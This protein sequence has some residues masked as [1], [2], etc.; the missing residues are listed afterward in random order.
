MR[1]ALAALYR[2]VPLR[3]TAPRR[4]REDRAPYRCPCPAHAVVVAVDVV[5]RV[6]RTGKVRA[7]RVRR[8]YL[9]LH[10]VSLSR[11][12]PREGVVPLRVRRRG[13]YHRAAPIDQPHRQP[14]GSTFTG[15]LLSVVVHVVPYPVPYAQPVEAE[16]YRQVRVRVPVAVSRRLIAAGYRDGRTGHVS[17][18]AQCPDHYTVIDIVHVAV[19]AV[20]RR[21]VRVSLQHAARGEVTLRDHHQVGQVRRKAR[22]EAREGIVSAVRR[23]R[24]RNQ[25]IHAGRVASIFIRIAVKLHRHAVDAHF[26][27]IDLPAVVRV[28]PHPVP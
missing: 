26:A 7:A 11:D 22:I 12:Q 13:R 19:P 24:R 14:S 5:P 3:A 18:A 8:R 21:A 16:V 9:H 10:R 1:P 28:V 17:A 15:I 23:G 2:V 4:R 6:A 20:G 25:F 27:R